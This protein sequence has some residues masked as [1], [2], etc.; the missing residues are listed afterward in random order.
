MPSGQNEQ[1]DRT[2]DGRRPEGSE[3][4]R[5][6]KWR[7]GVRRRCA[8]LPRSGPVQGSGPGTLDVTRVFVTCGSEALGEAGIQPKIQKGEGGEVEAFRGGG[9]LSRISDLEL[10]TMTSSGSNHSSS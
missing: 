6:L 9:P 3:E 8:D 1:G 10:A 5:S 4:A 2:R 7:S